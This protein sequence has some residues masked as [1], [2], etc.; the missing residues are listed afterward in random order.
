[1]EIKIE[2]REKKEKESTKER[3]RKEKKKEEKKKESVW[4]AYGEGGRRVNKTPH[5]LLDSYVLVYVCWKT[6]RIKLS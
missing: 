3:E 6:R 2:R 5:L 1:M 4:V